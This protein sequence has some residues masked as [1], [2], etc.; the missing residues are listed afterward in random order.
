M[1]AQEMIEAVLEGQDPNEVVCED[2]HY[3][4]D[5]ATIDMHYA[6]KNLRDVGRFFE[7]LRGISVMAKDQINKVFKG[8]TKL[9][10]SYAEMNHKVDVLENC[11]GQG[12]SL[13]I[14]AL[15]RYDIKGN[16]LGGSFYDSDDDVNFPKQMKALRDEVEIY[17]VVNYWADIVEGIMRNLEVD[18]E[19]YRKMGFNRMW[20]EE[21]A[22]IMEKIIG[23]CEELWEAWEE[24]SEQVY[25]GEE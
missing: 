21:I 10:P 13:C 12:L 19:R 15:E 3:S 7:N 5:N 20:S 17:E 24:I 18:P 14:K 22:A 23:C 8:R 2:S 16:R 1:N 6:P 9:N 11:A 4:L 25:E